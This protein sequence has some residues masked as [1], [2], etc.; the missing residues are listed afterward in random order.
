[1]FSGICGPFAFVNPGIRNLQPWNLGYGE[2]LRHPTG[3]GFH[4]L[5][6]SRIRVNPQ[7][8][9]KQYVRMFVLIR[10]RRCF[11]QRRPL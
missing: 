3:N 11:C 5:V 8:T 2:S 6:I 4:R 9:H 1:M 7:V 10:H